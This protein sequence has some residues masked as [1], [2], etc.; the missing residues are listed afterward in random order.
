LNKLKKEEK[1]FT[2]MTGAIITDCDDDNTRMRQEVRFSQLFGAIPSFVGVGANAVHDSDV[3]EVTADIM[4]AGSLIDVIDTS[5]NVVS[6]IDSP[7]AVVLVNVAPRGDDVKKK[8][9]N[10]TPFCAFTYKNV[11]VVSTFEG[12]TLS[13]ARDLGLVDEVMLFDIPT[14]ANAA[15]NQG[16][17]NEQEV[18]QLTHTQF[19]SLRFLPL[20]AY[21]LTQ[22]VDVP[23]EVVS[24][25]NHTAL[26][27]VVWCIDSFGNMKTTLTRKD[28]QAEEG[29]TVTLA[30]G[31][32]AK[33]YSRLADV[34]HDELALIEGSSGLSGRRFME[35]VIQRQNAAKELGMYI[36]STV[37]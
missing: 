19:R 22:K 7:Q 14:V 30:T 5:V 33:L 13:L 32:K 4:A 12:R 31:R 36:G 35:I 11:L 29:E 8:Y 15:L 23:H 16:L 9:D 21:W 1:E 10:G 17:I 26:T 25:E 2:A 18:H 37:L 27:N 34:P 28:L 20:V 6:S 3:K 24:L